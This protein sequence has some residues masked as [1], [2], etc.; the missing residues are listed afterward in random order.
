MG[1]LLPDGLKCKSLNRFITVTLELF[2]FGGPLKWLGRL[3]PATGNYQEPPQP[4]LAPRH[5]PDDVQGVHG[6]E[7]A[8]KHDDH[9][10]QH[11]GRLPPG[12]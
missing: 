1:T 8:G 3:V 2:P 4:P 7:T 6:E 5:S 11:L 10:H 12:P 9:S